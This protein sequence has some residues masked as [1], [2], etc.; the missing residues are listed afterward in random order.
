MRLVGRI[1]S[2]IFLSLVGIVSL[3]FA[4]I[5]LRCLFAGDFLLMNIP[6]L[7]FLTYLFR[8]L[9]F[10]ILFVFATYLF[11][12]LIKNKELQLVHFMI[13]VSLVVASLFTIAFYVLYVYLLVIVLA[14]IPFAIVVI[15]KLVK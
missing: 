5:E 2:Y 13:A 9:F 1:V 12:A 3:V 4:F 10:L 15:K 7:S 6:A 8:G 11:L 14:L